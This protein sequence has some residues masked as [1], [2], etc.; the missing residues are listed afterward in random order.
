[1]IFSSEICI[2]LYRYIA[3]IERVNATMKGK[4][5]RYVLVDYS[6]DERKPAA[7]KSTVRKQVV[8]P[9]ARKP[10]R[11]PNAIRKPGGLS[12][13]KKSRS[14]L[15]QAEDGKKVASKP[16]PTADPRKRK[17]VIVSNPEAG[18]EKKTE[19]KASPR[20]KK[21][22]IESDE[23]QSKS[24]SVSSEKKNTKPPT[25][26][27]PTSAGDLVESLEE[28]PAPKSPTSSV[29]KSTVKAPPLDDE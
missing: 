24:M 27:K 21:Q 20:R 26:S 23:A 6:D 8:D 17:S 13:N 11:K 29:G 22:K 2:P 4:G 25:K 3:I 16:S 28:A 9:V 14:L 12:H 15:I 7:R 19:T 1:M 10:G 5:Q 18:N